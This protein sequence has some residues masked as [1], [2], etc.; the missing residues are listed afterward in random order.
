M[1]GIAIVG[2]GLSGLYA[3]Y[4]LQE[5]GHTDYVVLEARPVLGGRIAS[6]TLDEPAPP[7]DR[8]APSPAAR[9]FDL[10]PTWFWPSYQPALS[11]LIDA[12]QLGRHAQY[13]AGE[14]VVE[15]AQG[16]PRR[17]PGMAGWP[18]SMR[19]AD[20]MGSL[21]DA[22][23]G[24]LEAGKIHADRRV[25]AVRRDG[26]A[27]D[28]EARDAQGAPS[29]YRADI[30]LLALPPRL[31]A[32]TIAFEPALPA[33]LEDTWRDTQTWMAPHAKYLAVYDRPFWREQGLSGA[34]RSARGPMAE[35][36]DAASPGGKAALFGFVGV[37]SEWSPNYPGYLAGAVEAVTLGLDALL[38]KAGES[39]ACPR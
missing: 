7:A 37:G 9:R 13:E 23:S 31:A 14:T 6:L 12:L 30:V 21:I 35:I 22:L 18:T 8:L 5:S 1:P 38:R 36:H 25:T 34:V 27:V 10:G 33:D 29:R 26:A 16:A 11:H 28:I 19:L 15:P 39:A 32:A 20:G 2:A 3:A 17:V 24:K 4:L